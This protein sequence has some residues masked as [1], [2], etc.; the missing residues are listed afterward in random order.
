M[1]IMRKMK[2]YI[3]LFV[4]V[5][6]CSC[7]NKSKG[8]ELEILNKEIIS[9]KSINNKAKTIITYKL[10]DY[11]DRNYYFNSYSMSKLIWKLKGTQI[12]NT[13][14]CFT[15]ENNI[16]AKC[17]N[18]SILYNEDYSVY[19]KIK[20]EEENKE[21]KEL[22]Y[23]IPGFYKTIIDKNNFYIHKGESIY[24]EYAMYLPDSNGFYIEFDINKKYLTELQL[25]SD[26]TNYKKILSRTVLRTIKEN[27]YEVYHGIIK[28]KN[29]VPIKFI[30]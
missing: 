8:L 24:F 23:K 19:Q 10:T 16:D 11:D 28:S 29:K 26:S 2:K 14:V 13:F 22:D 9:S 17:G 12:N 30:E 7:S 18:K 1:I 21:V 3:L 15:D 20:Y 6:L 4:L 5:C 25:F 27:G